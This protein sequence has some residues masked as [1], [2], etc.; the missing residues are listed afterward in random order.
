MPLTPGARLGEY[1]IL[2]SIGAGG[3]GEVYRARDPK[4]GREVAIKVLP[5]SYARDDER[6]RRFV[7]EAQAAAALDHPNILAIYHVGTQNDAP[8][9]VSELLKGSTLREA[10]G[11][12][13]VPVRKAVDYAIQIARG[14]A[15]A[16]DR[17]IVHRDLK[18]DNVFVTDDGRVKILDF[19]VAKLMATEPE[20][21]DRTMTVQ[22][23]VGTVL[24][25]AGYMA[26]EQLRGQPVDARADVFSFG[27]VLYEMLAGRR[28]FQKDSSA[29][30]MSAVLHDDPPE[31]AATGRPIPP[32]LNRIV[33]R[34]L[35]K[36]PQQRFQSARDVAFAL[37]DLSSASATHPVAVDAPS[38][39]RRWIVATAAAVLL[40]AVG[41]P[42]VATRGWF[43]SPAPQPIFH[44][45]TFR[46]GTL[47]SAR[48]APD[49]ETI[50]YG[51]AW[52]SRRPET[53]A[54]GL[55]SPESRSLGQPNT[56]I[57]S[58][59][60]KGELALSVR[61]DSPLPPVAGVLETMPL[62]GGAA[63]RQIHDRVEYADWAPD[64]SMAVT[65]DTGLGDRLEYPIGTPLYEV[66]G[67]IHMIRISPDGARVAFMEYA[68]RGDQSIA[69]IDRAKNRTTL[70][71]GW[72]QVNGLAWT[73]SG[74]EIWFAGKRKDEG[75][76]IY[77][78]SGSGGA[79]RVVERLPGPSNLYDLSRDGR[80]LVSLE[81]AS[82]G[83]R[84]MDTGASHEEDLSW[85]DM[86]QLRDISRDG[87]TVLF[88]EAGEGASSDGAIYIRKTDG[89]PA[90][91]LGSGYGHAFSPD[92]KWVLA[93]T[94]SGGDLSLIPT[95]PGTPQRLKGDV[96]VGSGRFLP[97]GKAIVFI[98]RGKDSKQY[99]N[100]QSLNGE[101][102]PISPGGEVNG[103]VVSPDG[104]TVATSIE[105][106]ACLIK[107]AGGPPQPL[108]WARP[109]DL[110]I[111]WSSDGTALF[112]ASR[113]PAQGIDR[114]VIAT[115]ARTPWK[116]LAPSDGAGVTRI[117]GVHLLDDGRL[118]GYSYERVLSQ[119]LVVSG[120]R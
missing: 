58:I 68:T 33:N 9:I 1:E 95:G 54:V 67:P 46:R 50:V 65:L 19:G 71:A 15:A 40:L 103:I 96:T 86:S 108:P 91:Q 11:E 36:Q 32:S 94:R 111:A 6:L 5:P 70:T 49:G 7:Q 23:G 66:E 89:S 106:Q 82:T 42:V 78:V 37:E 69:T 13:P 30:T 3:M 120:L 39:S 21:V 34:A 57:Y 24:G 59:S 20:G 72:L 115:G 45:L 75:W 92:G 101:P 10:L 14:L 105:R 64:G 99:L 26:P 62:L 25:T 85:L 98:A 27:A 16:H 90:V 47:A 80:A 112:M 31:L 28:A 118:Y 97:D 79:V 110:P 114:V 48:F 61:T 81:Q 12:G 53:F 44:P 76:G 41:A 55:T 22:T 116:T 18:P 104:T 17:G 63:P 102:R 93:S 56:D 84:F 117:L 60:S 2:G 35:E 77:A 52:D 113:D 107:L 29:D 38:K 73:A 100:V 119:L 88:T 74:G 8:F 4:L 83:I 109:G 51:A 87:R 43:R